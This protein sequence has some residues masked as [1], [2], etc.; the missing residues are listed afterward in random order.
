MKVNIASFFLVV[1]LVVLALCS[2]TAHA[3]LIKFDDITIHP[4]VF[5]IVPNGYNSFDWNNF[6][7]EDKASGPGTGYENGVVSDRNAAY[8][9]FA[10]DAWISSPNAFNLNSAYCT[11]A[12]KDNNILT[13]EGFLG[14]VSKGISI[15]SLNT[16]APTFINFNLFGIDS[17][18][19]SSSNQQFVMDN[20]TV[21]TVPE[22]ATLLGFGIPMLMVGL[23][24]L[25]GLRK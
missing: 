10:K 2:G 20:L 14:G 24:K 8:N 1:T 18:K 19:F 11:S 9:G 5:D 7:A 22:P 15:T 25:R 4:G 6:Y 3:T 13:V 16:A 17:A 12:L 21:N 23:G